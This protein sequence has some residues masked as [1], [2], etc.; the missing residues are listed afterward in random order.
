MIASV[1][2]IRKS[3]MALAAGLAMATGVVGTASSAQAVTLDA[4]NAGWYIQTGTHYAGVTNY[5]VGNSGDNG[6]TYRN[7]FVFDLTSVTDTITAADLKLWNPAGGYVSADAT[8]KYELYDVSTDINTLTA[9]GFGLTA[10]YD[11]LGT[12][13]QLGFFAAST[14]ANGTTV[15]ISLNATGLAYLNANRG[16]QVALGGTLTSLDA[17][18]WSGEMFFRNPGVETYGYQL[19]LVTQAPVPTPE[20]AT[21]A[22]GVMGLAG[23]TIA[24][25][26][27]R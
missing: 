7:F 1:N 19:E 6:N 16:Q 2:S 25:R 8:E 11:D 4:V 24:G 10:I 20:P 18:N 21:A 9:G 13:N 22:L 14:A 12:G 5:I 15:S 26:R 23:L 17:D 3:V 27:R